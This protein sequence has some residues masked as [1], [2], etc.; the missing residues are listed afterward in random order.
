MD[1]RKTM[2]L[3]E[4][5]LNKRITKRG[6]KAKTSMFLHE[7]TDNK[8]KFVRLAE[9]YEVTKKGTSK[10]SWAYIGNVFFLPIKIV[11]K[12][13][14]KLFEWSDK[15]GWKIDETEKFRL[16]RESIE[17]LSKELNSTKIALL[18]SEE[19]VRILS[20]EIA[21]REE[22]F[23]KKRDREFK[24]RIQQLTKEAD[25]F[26]SKLKN[27]ENDRSKEQDIQIFL[28]EHPWFLNLYYKDFKPQ[29]VSGMSRF[30]FYLKRFDE[31]QEV[32]ELKR[33]D[34]TF[35]NP[36]GTM[37]VEFA[38]A[39]N[40]LLEYFDDIIGVS[41]NVRASKYFGISEFY[42]R[43]ML[44]FGYKP[45]DKTQEFINRWKML[46]GLKFLHM[47]KF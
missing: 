44:I 32:I 3:E 47:I 19:K 20:L 10:K 4:E 7:Y 45:D 6:G 17:K 34:A 22:E 2:K 31:S 46:C 38:Q 11:S 23:K 43:G 24:N 1:K 42:P 27:F 37:N 36:D 35:R 9:A 14:K 25:E 29:K 12:F 21:K 41:S 30:D 33:P 18:E 8:E 15:Y 28:E 39:L 13:I 26:E 40:R 5:D 16:Q